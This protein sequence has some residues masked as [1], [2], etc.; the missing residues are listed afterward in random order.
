[1]VIRKST[2]SARK[3][4]RSARKTTRSARKTTRSARKSTRSARKA[5]RS[6]RKSTRSARKSTRSARK[7]TR[8]ARKSTHKGGSGTTHYKSSQ[9]QFVEQTELREM[10][11]TPQKIE[12]L[13]KKS[14]NGEE[15][16]QLTHKG[17]KY[18]VCYSTGVR[19]GR[20]CRS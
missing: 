8:S 16:F 5:T 10:P 12:Q 2:R 6:A 19:G 3:T 1:M 20:I 11:Q 15:G 13:Y 17:G 14:N 18:Q 9:R 4:T 7:A